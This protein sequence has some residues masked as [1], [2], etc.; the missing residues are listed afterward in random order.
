MWVILGLSAYYN[1]YLNEISLTTL[2]I[3]FSIHAFFCLLGSL[4]MVVQLHTPLKKHEFWMKNKDLYYLWDIKKVKAYKSWMDFILRL[5]VFILVLRYYP[6][7]L[8]IA[9]ILII[10]FSVQLIKIVMYTARNE[11][12]LSRLRYLEYLKEHVDELKI[13]DMNE[14][15]LLEFYTM[16][17]VDMLNKLIN[18]GELSNG[19]KNEESKEDREDGEGGEGRDKEEERETEERGKGERE[20]KEEEGKTEEY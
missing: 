18:N 7:R 11:Y 3:F 1:I 10:E 12:E 6:S 15:E 9:S 19:E 14:L 16:L 4:S 13:E 20:D 17:S 2:K 5:V 8:F